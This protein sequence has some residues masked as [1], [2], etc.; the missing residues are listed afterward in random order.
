MVPLAS[1]QPAEFLYCSWSAICLPGVQAQQLSFD[2]PLY[3]S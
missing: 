2:A 3:W 1:A